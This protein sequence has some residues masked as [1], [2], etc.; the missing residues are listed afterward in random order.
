MALVLAGHPFDT[1]K[2]RLQTEGKGGRFQGPVH[3]FAETIKKEGV[4][5]ASDVE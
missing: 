2:V 5:C 3:C 4:C 1:V